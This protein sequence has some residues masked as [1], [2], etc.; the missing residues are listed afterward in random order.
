MDELGDSVQDKLNDVFTKES[1]PYTTNESMLELINQIRLKNFDVALQAVLVATPSGSLMG[2]NEKHQATAQGRR[3]N[4]R[5]AFWNL[6][7]LGSL[8]EALSLRRRESDDRGL[9]ARWLN[10]CTCGLV[11]KVPKHH[12]SSESDTAYPCAE[13]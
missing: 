2:G 13:I 8:V 12:H 10:R 6:E 3:R 7:R 5:D 9:G 4:R 1:D 11:V